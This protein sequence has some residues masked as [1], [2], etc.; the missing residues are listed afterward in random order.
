MSC[1]VPIQTALLLFILVGAGALSGAPA[2]AKLPEKKIYAHY[3]GCFPIGHKAIRHH[4]L[5]QWKTMRHD[6]INPEEAHGGRF[7]NW[8]LLPPDA[9][10]TPAQ[11]AELEIRRAIRAGIDGFAIDAWAGGQRVKDTVSALF[12]AAERMDVPFEIT[13]CLDPSC[14]QKRPEGNH[15][16]TFTESISWLLK[17]HG[18]SAKL[19]RRDGKPLI[20]GYSTNDIIFDSAFR[21]LPEGPDKWRK[22]SDAYK[23]IERNVGQPLFFHCCFDGMSRATQGKP[24]LRRAAAEWAGQNFGAVGGFM[25]YNDKWSDHRDTIAAIKSGGAE[26]SQPLWPQYN[27]KD[28]GIATEPGTDKLRHLWENARETNSTLIQFVTWN[29][30]AEDTILAPGYSTGYTLL[31]LNRHFTDWWKQGR[32]PSVAKDQ[33]HLVF[34]RHVDGAPVFPFGVRRRTEPA[35][36]EVATLLAAPG[37][38]DVPSYGNYDAPAGL[39]T[40]QFPLRLGKVS[41]ALSRD[42]ARVL[43]V[44]APEMVTDRPFRED[45]SMVCFSSGFEEEWR[46]DFGDTPPLLYSENGDVDGDGLPNWFEMYWFGKFPDMSTATAAKPGD[47]PDGDGLTNLEEYFNQTDP[48]RPHRDYPSGFVWNLADIRQRGVSFNP[49]RDSHWNSVWSYAY[50][51]G[52]AGKIPHDGVYTRMPSGTKKVAYAGQFAQFSP[53]T[54]QNPKNTP[55]YRYLHGWIAHR[56]TAAG[57]WQLTMRPRAN[58][59]VVLNWHSPVNGQIRVALDIVEVQGRDPFILDIRRNKDTPPL[60]VETVPPGKSRKISLT[61]IA[62]KKGD[63]LHFVADG[64]P[65]NDSSQAWIENLEIVLE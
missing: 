46:A 37:R 54:R 22:I 65:S 38:V 62:V 60:C 5:Q 57:Q 50:K 40:R 33:I 25:G 10:L 30:Y 59:L 64:N 11:S 23:Q 28:G 42:G 12:E 61:N 29:D 1:T 47:D 18:R 9:E 51:Q 48:T 17:T 41:A 44:T 20:F 8:P 55:D 16:G 4:Y 52:E 34:R 6:S 49:D 26:W 63:I 3:M 2:D 7:V 43:S 58:A 14:H 45:N 13:L 19:A 32:E 31:S 27:N 56:K 21:A 35:T 24:A 53:S 15:I 36:L 39:H